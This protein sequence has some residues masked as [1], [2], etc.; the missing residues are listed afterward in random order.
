MSL[1]LTVFACDDAAVSHLA[2]VGQ[3]LADQLQS[4]ANLCD[5]KEVG[6]GQVRTGQDR[7]GQDRT[8]QDRT[9]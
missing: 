7:T 6:S 1:P 8:G 3:R 4:L 9:D 5:C 2:V